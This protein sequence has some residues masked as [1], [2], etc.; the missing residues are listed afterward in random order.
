MTPKCPLCTSNLVTPNKAVFIQE[1]YCPHHNYDGSPYVD[2]FFER[3]N[4]NVDMR[5]NEIVSYSINIAID[6][7][8]YGFDTN[9]VFPRTSILFVKDRMFQK[10]ITLKDFTS[11]PNSRDDIEH[12]IKRII[13]L[14]VFL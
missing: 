14:K 5:I 9:S 3:A 2:D 4:C 6:N 1:Y 13:N 7:H 11:F 8:M 12:V 10:L